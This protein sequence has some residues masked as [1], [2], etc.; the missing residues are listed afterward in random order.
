MNSLIHGFEQKD[1]GHIE[2][3]ICEGDGRLRIQYRD[4]G[5]GMSA[6]ECSRIFEPFY[7][8]KRSQ[9]G[10]GLG[11][12]IV[13]NLVRQALGGQITC[14]ST[15]GSGTIFTIEI[16]MTQGGTHE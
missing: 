7:T 6:E 5:K 16:P 11:L 15:H 4:D 10:S 3:L 1:Q 9:G 14:E 2:L 8:T 12:H 13:Y